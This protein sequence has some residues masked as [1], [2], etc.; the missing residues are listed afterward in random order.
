MKSTACLVTALKVQPYEAWWQP[1]DTTVCPSRKPV[2]SPDHIRFRFG[3]FPG[4]SHQGPR[5]ES[6]A[7][8][9]T[10]M[11]LEPGESG[12]S[13]LTHSCTET[14]SVPQTRKGLEICLD[15][16][17]LVLGGFVSLQMFDRV[18]RQT[19]SP[20]DYYT[21]IQH[22]AVIGHPLNGVACDPKATRQRGRGNEEEWSWELV[23]TKTCA[24]CG[25]LVDV[26]VVRVWYC[27]VQHQKS[28]YKYHKAYCSK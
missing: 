2:Y 11:D 15:R 5:P 8:K 28:H 24:Y 23:A 12:E 13:G 1:E 10:S 19:M 6:P 16:P 17:M 4:D 21:C 3:Y 26:R 9:S 7:A 27:D 25:S 22:A 14:M 20:R 18:Q